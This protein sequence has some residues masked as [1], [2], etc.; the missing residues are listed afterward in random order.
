MCTWSYAPLASLL[1]ER[2]KTTNAVEKHDSFAF[3][4]HKR[5]M[6]TR[7]MRV[8]SR[9]DGH[10]ALAHDKSAE[11]EVLYRPYS[12][13]PEKVLFFA[14]LRA[15]MMVIKVSKMIFLQRSFHAPR[16]TILLVSNLPARPPP[17]TTI[18]LRT[19]P[20]PRSPW[21][22]HPHQNRR[23]HHCRFIRRLS[24]SLS[25]SLPHTHTHTH[26]HG[27]GRGQGGC[28]NARS[29]LRPLSIQN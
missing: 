5:D 24:L 18:P 7:P 20:L 15:D 10:Q 17:P 23:Q 29:L 12:V 1:A 3:I 25:L 11:Q 2:E 19:I 28:G 13:K 8:L 9:H 26:T 27:S 6:Y 16:C 21:A 14:D 4:P 22:L